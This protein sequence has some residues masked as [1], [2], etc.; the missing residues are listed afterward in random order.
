MCNLLF[1]EDYKLPLLNYIPLK[2]GR[3]GLGLGC[4]ANGWMASIESLTLFEKQSHVRILELDNQGSI[5]TK[6]MILPTQ[7]FL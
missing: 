6:N 1:S 3:S 2:M 4:I 5:P 7:Y